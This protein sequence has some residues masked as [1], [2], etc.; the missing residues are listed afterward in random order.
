[1]AEGRD[2]LAEKREAKEA[3]RNP[4]P[5]VPTFAGATA[6][7]IELRQPTW[8]NP[9]HAGQWKSTLETY[10]FPVIGNIAVDEIASADVLAA[11]WAVIGGAKLYRADGLTE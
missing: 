2:P 10:A 4:T 9:K 7:V 3:A 11:H 5:S 6:R 1:M 8:K